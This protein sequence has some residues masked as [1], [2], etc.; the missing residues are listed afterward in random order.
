MLEL[1]CEVG[2]EVFKWVDKRVTGPLVDEEER[3]E[4]STDG[5]GGA[6]TDVTMVEVTSRGREWGWVAITIGSTKGCYLTRIECG[7]SI[8]VLDVDCRFGG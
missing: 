4:G 1:G 5:S 3:V 6:K 8:K 2:G 7:I